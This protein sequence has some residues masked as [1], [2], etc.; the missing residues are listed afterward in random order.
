[1]GEL[2]QACN[3]AVSG[4][5]TPRRLCF[6]FFSYASTEALKIAP[7]L[8]LEEE[9]LEAGGVVCDS[10]IGAAAMRG[11]GSVLMILVVRLGVRNG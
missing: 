4:C 3:L 5:V 7:K 11:L 1:M 9:K 8:D 2:S 6:V 10:D